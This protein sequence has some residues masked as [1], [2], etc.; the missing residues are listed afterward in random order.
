MSGINS[1]KSNSSVAEISGHGFRWTRIRMIRDSIK[2]AGSG[3]VR[4]VCLISRRLEER[5]DPGAEPV[6]VA[7]PVVV[8]EGRMKSSCPRASSCREYSL[9]KIAPLARSDRRARY[10]SMLVISSLLRILQQLTAFLCSSL[11]RMKGEKREAGG[12][13]PP[14][15]YTCA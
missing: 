2:I 7:G 6:I 9:V 14:L 4:S 12:I 5:L 15:D 13:G 1:D 10:E 3:S 11:V 8:S